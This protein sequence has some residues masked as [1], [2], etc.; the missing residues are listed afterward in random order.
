MVK[1]GAPTGVPNI[2]KTND[3]TITP[4]PATQFLNVT[5]STNITSIS[6]N[7]IL[8]QQVFGSKYNA[9]MA[10]ID[11]SALPN[12]MYFIKVNN[13]ETSRFVKE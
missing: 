2:H 3:F 7:N 9:E 12:G 5:A 4:N 10:K 13:I 8:G 1:F 6:V 11:V